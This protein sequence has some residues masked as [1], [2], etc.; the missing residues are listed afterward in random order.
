MDERWMF[1][2][3]CKVVHEHPIG[4]VE[5]RGECLCTYL[6]HKVREATKME[7]DTFDT[8]EARLFD[9]TIRA[10]KNDQALR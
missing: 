7:M 4:P 9:S 5:K 6:G 2:E 3:E 8:Y 1:C 10:I